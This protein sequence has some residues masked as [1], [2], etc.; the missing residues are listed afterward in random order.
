MVD[1][2]TDNALTSASAAA[3]LAGEFAPDQLLLPYQ[4]RWIADDAQIKIA[5]KSRR[6][7]LTWAE[8]ADA[9]LNG[10][11]SREAGGCDTFYVGTTKDMAREFID[12]CAMWAK[13]YDRAAS[14]IGEEVLEDED[15]DILVYVIQFASG[16]K[17][18]AL[19]SNPS[20]LRGMQGNV[21]ID[22]AAFQG[23][24][25]ALLKAALALTMWGAKVRIISTHN[26]IEHLFN[27][28]ITE[29]RA[30]KRRYSVHRVDIE[31][32]IREGLYK[33]I[34]QVTRQIWSLAAEAE[35]LENLL[36]DTAT[37]EDAREEYYCEPKNGGGTYLAR[38]IRERAARG[39]GPVL[40]F[41]G[42]TEFNATPEGVR[43]LDM[44][45]WLER[46]VLPELNK[47]PQNLRHCLGEDFARSGH[48][49]VFAPMTVNDDTTRTVPFLVEFANVPYKQ[50]EQALFFI[51]DRLPR[52]D[53]IKLDGRGNGNY[54]AEQAAER[55]GDE[56]EVV[57]PSVG[58]YR[59]NMPRFKS[60]FEDDE[61]VLPKHEDVI[62]D[63]GQIVILRGTPG[64]DD[65]ENTGSDGHKRHGDS[66]YAIFLAFL[67]SK[68]DCRR[69][70]LHRL[71]NPTQQRNR[72]SAR[73]LRT[74]RGLKNQR[75]LL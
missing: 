48:L 9:A 65:R 32:A 19:S 68:E 14:E 30:G 2:I 51:C 52:R 6:T 74:T 22:E 56:V 25:A 67:A 24:L 61:L 36:S 17:I 31:T 55:Y 47:L 29:C 59:E 10:S 13:A 11:M 71:N 57:M 40:R 46:I 54:L 28:L 34:C 63:L 60:A 21:I 62:S 39:S 45:D 75:G 66:A 16:F 69:Y 7:G 27:T 18:K 35:W 26:G 42:S 4:K 70:E 37:E 20:N 33:R 1:M 73:Q 72:D 38:S 8:A 43:A 5:E 41:T 50:Q 64:I 58:H 44:Q 12:A 23:D 3:I 15:K 49:T 53:G